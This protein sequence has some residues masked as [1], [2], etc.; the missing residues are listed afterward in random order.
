MVLLDRLGV[1][2]GAL[3]G[4]LLG[5][6]LG[7]L[8]FD[9]R[10]DFQASEQEFRTY[11]RRQGAF[12]YHVFSLC[13]KMAKADGPINRNEVNFME[14]LMRQQF[15]L[16]DRA[17]QDVIRV[18]AGESV[19][20]IR[21]A[22]RRAGQFRRWAFTATLVAMA[23]GGLA[24]GLWRDRQVARRER[25]L[26]E[27]VVRNQ[28]TRRAGWREALLSAT[29]EARFPKGD[30]MARS[31][32][33]AALDGTDAR[34]LLLWTNYP[35]HSLAF[36]REGTRAIMGGPE[37]IT[38]WVTLGSDAPRSLGH[39]GALAVAFDPED[40]PIELLQMPGDHLQILR[41]DTAESLASLEQPVR[42]ASP[43]EPPEDEPKR[44]G[45]RFAR[46]ATRLAG[47]TGK[48]LTV[49]NLPTGKVQ[50]TAVRETA[51]FSLDESGEMLAMAQ[52][53]GAI[54]VHS[55]DVGREI[56]IPPSRAA[57][58]RSLALARD[59]IRPLNGGV[60]GWLLAAGD[61]AGMITVWDLS[62]QT[63]RTQFR[64]SYLDMLALAFSSDGT[65]L[66]SGGRGEVQLWDLA[67]GKSVLTELGGD[68]HQQVAFSPEGNRIGYVTRDG[69]A[70]GYSMIWDLKV[71]SSYQTLRGL[72]SGVGQPVLS[73]DGRRV[74]GVSADWELGVWDQTSGRL[75]WGTRVPHGFSA[76]HL[77]L[78]FSAD[79][80]SLAF[81]AGRQ[82]RLWRSVDGETLRSWDLVPGI[83]DRLVFSSSGRLLAFRAEYR[84]E[85]ASRPVQPEY[86]HLERRS[87][88]RD[89]LTPDSRVLFE[90]GDF[91]EGPG[92]VRFSPDGQILVVIGRRLPGN[93]PQ[94]A[95]I[96]AHDTSSGRRLWQILVPNSGRKF[97][98]HL[99]V[100]STGKV[101][102]YHLELPVFHSFV[103]LYT[104][105]DQGIQTRAV[106]SA[107]AA[108]RL[109]SVKYPFHNAGEGMAL[110]DH[111]GPQLILSPW[112][113]SLPFP[114]FSSDGSLGV[115]PLADGTLRVCNFDR[116]PGEL[117]QAGIP[118]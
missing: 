94:D 88:V 49:W 55:L 115:W 28:A 105:A 23:L 87:V 76:D 96:Q 68:F 66:A 102:G 18:L 15:R 101:A 40:R 82:A 67:T 71:S 43:P 10:R 110:H 91:P 51:C 89:L 54:R 4:F 92:S 33:V 109:I 111:A 100:D 93:Q 16:T 41:A 14:R 24:A 57:T 116:L 62:S 117:A 34:S 42:L 112:E 56:T 27:L 9:R 50:W 103:D 73:P 25:L 6:A 60:S 97:L 75:L 80:G 22:Q 1:P 48:Q 36:D 118:W 38:R 20:Q 11:Q 99:S 12:V 63:I 29:R 32:A 3:W 90:V 39:T 47:L 19:R 95:V 7:H 77:G 52:R 79:G 8:L 64:G 65:L 72:S 31:L 45:F 2:L 83:H 74:A 104:G 70:P 44:P 108:S 84:P 53:S 30:I 35:A 114:A 26:Q 107:R 58:I 59:P 17:R 98:S 106:V 69:F 113:A 61:S 37:V 13:A 78:T 5:S 85:E 86:E 81:S 46:Q 21:L